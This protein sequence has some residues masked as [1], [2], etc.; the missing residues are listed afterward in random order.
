MFPYPSDSV[1]AGT[2]RKSR[3]LK[4][5]IKL[6]EHHLSQNYELILLDPP[7]LSNNSCVLSLF[8]FLYPEF[9]QLHEG[10]YTTEELEL[11]LQKFPDIT[12]ITPTTLKSQNFFMDLTPSND[13]T[14]LEVEE[15]AELKRQYVV[16]DN[17]V[18][19]YQ[20]KYL[21]NL[22][23]FLDHNHLYV[24]LSIN[25]PPQNCEQ[26]NESHPLLYSYHA[27]KYLCSQ[28]RYAA[29]SFNKPCYVADMHI[30]TFGNTMELNRITV[31]TTKHLDFFI[32]QPNPGPKA[33]KQVETLMRQH[34]RLSKF[35]YNDDPPEITTHTFTSLP[36]FEHW[37]I[38]ENRSSRNYYILSQNGAKREHPLIFYHFAKSRYFNPHDLGFSSD[39]VHGFTFANHKFLDYS[40]YESSPTPLQSYIQI[41]SNF[42]HNADAIIQTLPFYRDTPTRQ[43]WPHSPF[44]NKD[45][46]W[47]HILRIPFLSVFPTLPSLQDAITKS[48]SSFTFTASSFKLKKFL[49]DPTSEQIHK[50]R[51]Q[52]QIPLIK[53]EKGTPTHHNLL[54]RGQFYSGVFL[55]QQGHYQDP[56]YLA[57]TK[58]NHIF[59]VLNHE[60]YETHHPDSPFRN[61]LPH[62]FPYRDNFPLVTKPSD[63]RTITGEALTQ[64]IPRKRLLFDTQLDFLYRTDD[65][66]SIIPNRLMTNDYYSR[67]LVSQHYHTYLTENNLYPQFFEHHNIPPQ[68]PKIQHS[69]DGRICVNE[70]HIQQLLTYNYKFQI[71]THEPSYFYPRTTSKPYLYYILAPLMRIKEEQDHYKLTNDPRFNPSLLSTTKLAL[72]AQIGYTARN[73]Q[74]EKVKFTRN[75][76]YA[77][78]EYLD[79]VQ[80]LHG[81]L[82]TTTTSYNKNVP[83]PMAGRIYALSKIPLYQLIH[84]LGMP[85]RI[86]CDS[87]LLPITPELEQLRPFLEGTTVGMFDFK[88]V[89]E[90][91]ILSDSG[92]IAYLRFDDDTEKIYFGGLPKEE[93]AKIDPYP[94]FLQFYETKTYT[95]TYNVLKKQLF[96]TSDPVSILPVT[97]TFKAHSS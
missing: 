26:C 90:S 10:P 44:T 63:I 4:R 2:T 42:I 81:M 83:T 21:E 87:A 20:R 68:E 18:F 66:I 14:P 19:Q 80:F 43:M 41:F 25:H 45:Y 37:L 48:I 11:L 31:N 29:R 52:H 85:R 77:D 1:A 53:F 79:D 92:N 12:L 94:T 76:T 47:T 55:A 28:C 60:Y 30:T 86:A 39:N 32:P 9:D 33:H 64:L 5:N 74:K 51:D 72:V 46:A 40:N 8:N 6:T 24:L 71:S 61:L 59:P 50:I 35:F 67:L 70:V 57:D 23:L 13:F 49:P 75:Y 95:H 34:D 82:M 93:Q 27:Q 91:I 88:K 89:D 17:K 62:F 58:S 54:S 96:R 69:H 22:K 16:H 84:H 7:Q 97:K 3:I 73:I 78:I 15:S 56:Q 38:T 65:T 36:E